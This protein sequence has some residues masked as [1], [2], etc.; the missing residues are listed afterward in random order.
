MEA[1][2]FPWASSLGWMVEEEPPMA[3]DKGAQDL[4][5]LSRRAVLALCQRSCSCVVTLNN[6][7][8][9]IQHHMILKHSKLNYSYK[10][11]FETD[12]HLVS[13]NT[14]TPCTP[15]F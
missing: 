15:L 9:Y 12:G 6:G 5:G 14:A 2:M 10:N 4:C 11:Y 8:A 3:A 1:F 13:H 7:F